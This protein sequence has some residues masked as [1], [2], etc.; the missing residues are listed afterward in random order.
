[1]KHLSIRVEY[2][3]YSIYNSVNGQIS[4]CLYFYMYDTSY[5]KQ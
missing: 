2:I 1:M 4:F 5:Y 3:I